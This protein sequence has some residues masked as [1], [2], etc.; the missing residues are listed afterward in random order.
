MSKR[1]FLL[2]LFVSLVVAVTI[3]YADQRF[4]NYGRFSMPSVEQAR[5]PFIYDVCNSAPPPNS[6]VWFN[7]DILDTLGGQPVQST[8][9]L[10]YSFDNQSSWNSSSMMPIDTIGY[11]ITYETDIVVLGSGVVYYF[12]RAQN[13]NGYYG[14]QSPINIG[15]I[16]PTPANL[17]VSTCDEVIGDTTGGAAGPWLDL[18]GCWAG[19]SQ[20]WL[21]IKLSNNGG[22]WPWYENFIFGPW[23]IYGGGVYNPEAPSDTF[24]YTLARVDN[25]IMSSCLLKINQYT[26]DF[27]DI[28]NIDETTN[29]DSLWLRCSFADLVNDPHFGPW[30]NTSGLYLSGGT[31]TFYISGDLELNDYAE[32]GRFYRETPTFTVGSNTPPVLTNP[33]VTPQIGGPTTIFNFSVT[34][35]DADNN[36]PTLKDV[37]IDGMGYQMSSDDHS[38]SDGSDFTFSETSFSVGDHYFYFQFSDGIDTVTTSEDTFKVY[39]CDAATISIDSPPDSVVVDSTYT[40]MATVANYDSTEHSFYVTCQIDTSGVLVYEDSSFVTNLASRDSVQVPFTDWTVGAVPYI[41]YNLSVYTQLAGDADPLNDTLSKIIISKPT[42]IAEEPDR[43]KCPKTFYLSQNFPNPFSTT[44]HISLTF[45]SIGHSAKGIELNIYD[46]SGRLVKSFPLFTPHS[47]PTIAVSWDGKDDSGNKVGNGIYL[48]R[49]TTHN[50]KAIKKIV[51][52]GR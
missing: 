46:I 4:S 10:W 19:Y 23:Y 13:S 5:I 35:T 9:T 30:P 21:Y 37:V 49:L 7:V 6:T 26:G 27:W 48:L 15:N 52:I 31:S 12:I 41:S 18:T 50:F 25:P 14:T 17:L 22:G 24:A 28:G 32:P 29:A 40:P 1:M 2:V 8:V 42:G 51:F 16:F 11:K 39:L 20:D 34:Y 44:T 3:F 36:L 45:P 33:M 43:E 38:Y 47:S